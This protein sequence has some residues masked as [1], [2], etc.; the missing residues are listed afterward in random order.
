MG[1]LNAYT[2]RLPIMFESAFIHACI[3][4]GPP[5]VRIEN[6]LTA[7]WPTLQFVSRIFWVNARRAHNCYVLPTAFQKEIASDPL[8]A[9]LK[10]VF[11]YG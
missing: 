8:F 7:V 5:P 3:I 10:G 6:P 1:N 2:K 11:K 9:D 4:P